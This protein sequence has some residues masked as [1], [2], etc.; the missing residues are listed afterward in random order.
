LRRGELTRLDV[1][2]FDQSEGTLRIDGR[3]TGRERW[4]PLPELAVR[5]LEAYLPRRHNQLE[6]IGLIE[7]Q[8]LLIS[9]GFQPSRS[10]TAYMPFH[11][12][13]K[14]R[15]TAF[16]SFVTALRRTCLRPEFIWLRCP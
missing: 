4:V 6:Q 3:K 10:A 14:F 7:E 16:I 2:A 5:C 12:A 13:S 11:A 1:D 9:C 15:F 8:V